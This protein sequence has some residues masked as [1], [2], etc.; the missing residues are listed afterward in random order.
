MTSPLLSAHVSVF[1]GV[2]STS[3][4]E[5]VRLGAMLTRIQDGSYGDRIEALRA[6]RVQDAEAYRQQKTTLPAFTPGCALTT[7]AKKVAW[8]EKLIAPTQIVHLDVDHVDAPALKAQVSTDPSV[9]FAFVSPSGEGL[10]LG[11]AS[12]GI[13]DTT[14]YSQVWRTTITA[15]K[16]RFPD[17]L[18]KEDEQVKYLHAL[19]FVS[20]DA[21]LYLNASAVPF[22]PPSSSPSSSSAKEG[23][24]E[25]GRSQERGRREG[26]RRETS[27]ERVSAALACI[28]NHDADYDTWLMLGMALHSTGE[29][30]A[31]GLWDDWSRQSEKYDTHKQAASWASF[32][33]DGEVTLGSLFHLAQQHGY[34]QRR[35]AMPV[36]GQRSRPAV[37]D[38]TGPAPENQDSA[39]ENAA[40]PL[41]EHI[42]NTASRPARDP[43]ALPYSDYTNALA[44]VR[45]R[46]AHLRYCYPWGKWLVWSGTHWE[47]DT[48]GT[49][50]RWAKDT[51][52]RL[53]RHAED[54]DDLSA[55]GA[56]LKHVKASLATAKLKAMAE[57]AQ[58]ELGIPVQLEDLDR[59]PWGLNV[60]NGTL[61]LRT[62]ALQPHTPTDLLT[63][64]LSVRYDPH[65]VC[66]TWDAFLDRI[67]AG[68]TTLIR[69]LQRAVGY[70]LT[71]VFREHVLLILWGSGR[72]G[73]STFLNTLRFLLGPY[74][75][76]APSELLMVSNSDRHPTERADLFGKRFVAAIETEQGRRLAEVFVKEATGGDPIRARRMREDFWEF[77]PTHK[78]FLAT[79]HKP[80]ITGTDNAIWERMRLVP[81]TVTIPPA[82][83]DTTLPDKLAAELPGILA[84]AVRGCQAWQQEGLGDPDEIHQATAG[85]RAE[86][87]VLGG[88]IEECC[89]TGDHYRVKAATLYN[90][91]KHWCEQNGEHIEGQR[92]WGI[93]LTERGFERYTNNGTWYRNIAVRES[94]GEE[95]RN[96]V[97]NQRN[98]TEP[99]S[100]INRDV[101]SR[102]GKTRK[103]G[104]VG[105]VPSVDPSAD[106]PRDKFDQ[107]AF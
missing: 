3:V 16:A 101:N 45:D 103:V 25:G 26:G 66:P 10:K 102:E 11:I 53:A 94:Y 47:Q 13:T 37:P 59:D 78:V 28:P 84:W 39:A 23:R 22:L 83:R 51:I 38:M 89:L 17:A 75:M 19:C 62:G 86:M 7:R 96:D 76:K 44:F 36:A 67:M 33:R 8:K 80:V 58:S 104:S 95:T 21:D 31:R 105:S 40:A 98:H 41:D 50:L 72:N 93:A 56:L 48:S 63:R 2:R 82:E 71:G 60:A 43:D 14:S 100:G 69:F 91:Y 15:W 52:K 106:V 27:Y 64:C 65:A 92:H 6:L 97:R 79:N 5:Q 12:A 85:Y 99:I 73:K 32:T 88:F 29:S 35:A 30:W 9:V 68:N 90:T 70:G 42:Y 49:V 46:G 24:R 1:N 55:I 107:G 4:V 54:L 87:D 81:F 61:N 77:P 20:H 74:A 57:S 18:F 34:V